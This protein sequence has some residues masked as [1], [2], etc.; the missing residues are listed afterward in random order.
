VNIFRNYVPIDSMI[1]I[2]GGAKSKVWRQMMA[3]IYN[4]KI[5]KPKYLE[6]ATSM[7]AAVI[8]GIGVG[9]FE[10]FDAISKFIKI[11]SEHEPNP[12]NKVIYEKTYQV[13]LHSYDALVDIYEEL[14]K[15]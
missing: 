13:F 2:G 3:D 8:G 14:A 7:G 6:E 15:L 4:L 1:V 12:D 11:E 9:E 10:S 5:L